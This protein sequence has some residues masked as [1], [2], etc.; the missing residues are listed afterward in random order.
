[1]S[2]ARNWI[3]TLNNP[4]IEIKD[5]L[6]AWFTKGKAAYVCGQLEKGEEGTPHIQY[7]LNFK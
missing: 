4:D 5:Y 6:E 1:M 2:R 7:Y 3:C